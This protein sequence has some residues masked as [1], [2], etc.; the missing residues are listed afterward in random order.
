LIDQRD[1]DFSPISQLQH[2]SSVRLAGWD[3]IEIP[4][5]SA[6]PSI[7]HLEISFGSLTSLD[8]IET[9]PSLEYLQ[10]YENREHLSDISA[11]RHLQ[12]LRYLQITNGSADLDFSVLKD[13]PELQKLY[14]GGKIDLRGISQLKSLQNLYLWGSEGSLTNIEEIGKMTWLKELSLNDRITSVEFLANNTNLEDLQLIA[15]KER[16]DFW[17]VSLPLDVAPLQNLTNLRELDFRGFDLI[18]DEK[19]YELPSLKSLSFS[20]EE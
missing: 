9:M 5:F 11:L 8:G 19:L 14:S 10:I 15:D 17:E 3:F 16:E 12:N 18:N 2:L 20:G 6:N 13:L 4:D 7:K 1:V